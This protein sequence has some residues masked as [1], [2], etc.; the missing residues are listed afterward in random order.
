MLLTIM[1][2]NSCT[3]CVCIEHGL[4]DCA[5]SEAISWVIYVLNKLLIR[6][7]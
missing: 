6:I 7:I 1:Y 4:N 3:R 2:T 5:R